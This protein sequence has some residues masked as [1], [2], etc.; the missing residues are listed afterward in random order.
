MLITLVDIVI[1]SLI[2]REEYQEPPH[3]GKSPPW[4]RYDFLYLVDFKILF[5]L[6]HSAIH[7]FEEHISFQCIASHKDNMF[8]RLL[9]LRCIL[10][11]KQLSSSLCCPFHL[12]FLL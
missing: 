4:Q 1:C 2:R 3:L 5:S 6:C 7:S 9:V 11:L 10:F 8:C 12:T